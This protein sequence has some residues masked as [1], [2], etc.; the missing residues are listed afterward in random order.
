MTAATTIKTLA[1][2]SLARAAQMIVPSLPLA[3]VFLVSVGGM[4]WSANTLPDDAIGS[5]AF[6]GVVLLCLF[7]HSLFSAAMYRA[8][9]PPHGGLLAAA[10]RLTLAWLLMIV[11]VSIIAAIIVLFFSLF[12]TVLGVAM[13]DETAFERGE[14]VDIS[15]Q[16]RASGVFL[17]MFLVFLLVLF[18]VF[19]FAVRMMTFAAASVS[20]GGVHVFRTWFWTKHH[21][22]QLA[23]L[24]VG[25]IALPV[26][27]SSALGAAMISLI[28]SPDGPFLYALTAILFTA[29]SLPTAWLGHGFAAAVYTVLAPPIEP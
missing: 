4:V 13:G 15:E 28:P 1:K 16:M 14:V 29:I 18:W 6:I 21:F 8:S 22:R 26:I 24:M 3:G 20:R 17:P 12:G 9:L 5:L 2:D 11:V 19:W 7:A 25:L 27:I 23:P 10:W